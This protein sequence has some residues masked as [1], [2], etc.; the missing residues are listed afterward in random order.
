MITFAGNALWHLVQQSD[1]ISKGV[2]LVLLVLSIISWSLFLGKIMIMRTHIKQLQKTICTL[3]MDLSL[4]QLFEKIST[5]EESITFSF[6]S[7]VCSFVHMFFQKRDLQ[8][9]FDQHEI[10]FIMNYSDQTVDKLIE[11]ERAGLA[12]LSTTA[13]IS[14]LLGLFGTVWGLVHAFIRISQQQSA[15]IATVAPGIAE[16][17][18]TTLAGLMVAIPALIMFNYMQVQ[19]RTVEC[20]LQ[21]LADRVEIIIT[22]CMITRKSDA[23]IQKTPTIIHD[24]GSLSHATR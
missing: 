23:Q 17:L 1:T 3:R 10:D 8:K 15:D 20:L 5:P 14:P 11:K 12:F 24:D 16:A 19:A 18:I 13:G 4:T 6:L 21:Q 9:N 2:L 22:C 7:T